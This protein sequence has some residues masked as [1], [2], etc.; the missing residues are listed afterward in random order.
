MNTTLETL[1][2]VLP[3]TTPMMGTDVIAATV[4][5][6]ISTCR[7]GILKNI[8]DLREQI[9]MPVTEEEKAAFEQSLKFEIS[10]LEKTNTEQEKSVCKLKELDLKSN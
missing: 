6:S 3:R 2:S 7:N 8:A 1:K 10:N 9:K 4:A 5:D